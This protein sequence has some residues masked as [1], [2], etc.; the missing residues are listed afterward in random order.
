VQTVDTPN[1][2]GV[3]VAEAVELGREAGVVVTSGQLDG[4]PLAALTWPGLWLVEAQ[5]PQ[6]GT[7][8]SRGSVLRITF[9]ND[10][11]GDEGGDREPRL[12]SPDP[13][14]LETQRQMDE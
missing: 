3:V 13:G 2:V 7:P 10:G 9:R 12:P 1:V 4:P 11:G 6:P 14:H 5:D 8:V